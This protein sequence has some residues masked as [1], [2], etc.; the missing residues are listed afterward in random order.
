MIFF[1]LSNTF[2]EAL[3]LHIFKKEILDT[4]SNKKIKIFQAAGKGAKRMIS[5][6]LPY[7]RVSRD[8]NSTNAWHHRDRWHSPVTIGPHPQG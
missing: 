6:L 4:C 7:F 8:T 3:K 2:L 1:I 5:N